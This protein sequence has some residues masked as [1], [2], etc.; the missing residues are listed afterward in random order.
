MRADRLEL[1]RA[2]QAD[3]RQL[4]RGHREM[5]RP[6]IDQPL[7]ERG[8]GRQRRRWRARRPRRHNPGDPSRCANWRAAFC[9]SVR[10]ALTGPARRHRGARG[11]A[12]GAGAAAR[13]SSSRSAAA[14]DGGCHHGGGA[15]S[16]WRLTTHLH[17]LADHPLLF[18]I[19]G[20]LGGHRAAG[21]G[22]GERGRPRLI[23]GELRQQPCLRDRSGDRVARSGAEP[24]AVERDAGCRHRSSPSA[25]LPGPGVRPVLSQNYAVNVRGGRNP[26]HRA[27]FAPI[28]LRT[29]GPS[30]RSACASADR[31]SDQD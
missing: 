29:D 28:G 10:G 7:D 6:E 23:G 4:V 9:A 21:R 14:G 5:V 22:I 15:A 13:R 12:R 8:V 25:R 20:K 26:S 17:L 27:A 24:E 11:H 16:G 1:Q 31:S 3:D 19:L 30:H 2:R 18:E